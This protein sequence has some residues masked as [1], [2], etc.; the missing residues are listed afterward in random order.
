MLEDKDTQL[1]VKQLLGHLC[2]LDDQHEEPATAFNRIVIYSDG[3][4][5]IQDNAEEAIISFHTPCELY[6]YLGTGRLPESM[7]TRVH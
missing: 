6:G 3:S 7:E 2:E 4:G 1:D 5:E